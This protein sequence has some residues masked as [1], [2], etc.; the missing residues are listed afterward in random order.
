M[1]HTSQKERGRERERRD[2]E[3]RERERERSFPLFVNKT[4]RKKNPVKLVET[5]KNAIFSYIGHYYSS[6][7]VNNHFCFLLYKT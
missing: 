4:L 2:R 5:V 7:K 6:E 1:L 3:K